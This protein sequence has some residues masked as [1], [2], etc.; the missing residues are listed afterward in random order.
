MDWS[1]KNDVID[2][3]EE[4]FYRAKLHIKYE[5]SLDISDLKYELPNF[6]C[7]YKGLVMEQEV[8]TDFE[9]VL[10]PNYEYN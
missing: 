5:T 1:C 7:N 8:H 9:F 4:N 3:F 10:P 6:I 2:W